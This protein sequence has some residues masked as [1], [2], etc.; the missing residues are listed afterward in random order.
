[1]FENIYEYIFVLVYGYIILGAH[2]CGKYGRY[3]VSC[4]P[5][6]EGSGRDSL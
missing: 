2:A 5:S 6:P 1:M 4:Y 3:D